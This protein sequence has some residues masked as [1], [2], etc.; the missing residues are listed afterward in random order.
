MAFQTAIIARGRCGRVG[1][2]SP[3]LAEMIIRLLAGK[4]VVDAVA[5]RLAIALD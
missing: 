1:R 3:R 4:D 2:V 5:A